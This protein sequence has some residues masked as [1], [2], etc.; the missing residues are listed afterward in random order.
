VPRYTKRGVTD[1]RDVKQM[2]SVNF[3]QTPQTRL[4][5][6][7]QR[8]EVCVVSGFVYTSEIWPKISSIRNAGYQQWY[9]DGI[10]FHIASRAQRRAGNDPADSLRAV[11]QRISPS[12]CE[13]GSC[14]N[15][16]SVD[17]NAH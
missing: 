17:D 15:T 16:L 7:N 13:S 3:E 4:E 5:F 14:A 6:A 8:T 12:G 1:R 11:L 9:A 2:R 10:F